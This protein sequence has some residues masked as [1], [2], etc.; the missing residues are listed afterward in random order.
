M[1][2]CGFRGRGAPAR[3]LPQTIRCEPVN[4]ARNSVEAQIEALARS[5]EPGIRRAVLAALQQQQSKVVLRALVE[6]IKT[7]STANVLSVL[8]KAVTPASL[9]SVQQALFSGATGAGVAVA[10]DIARITRTDFAFG[11]LNPRLIEWLQ[12]Y[13]FGLIREIND[14]TREGVR[15]IVSDGIRTGKGPVDTARQIKQIVGLTERQA[16]AVAN[17]RRELETFHLKR[18]A[19]S[20][21]LGREI[22]R[23][24]G[25]QVFKPGD[26][27]TAKDGIDQR[28]L[29]DFRFDGKLASAVETGKPLDPKQI[30]KMV[31]AYAAKYRRYRSETIAITEASRVTTMGVQDA[32]RQA[33]EANVADEALVRRQ[34]VVSADERLCPECAPV[35]SMN[36]RRGV[37]FNEPFKTPKGPVFLPGLHPRCRCKVFIRLLEKSQLENENG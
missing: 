21:G 24:N 35:P 10:R 31:D 20:Y 3:Y 7:G 34:W 2:C 36:P 12:T 19:G 37:K 22:D 28:R 4:K 8:E 30:D 16:K 1:I 15:A 18:S 14:K 25:R 11:V 29:R 26:D 27:G 6:A 5:L 23:V 13:S 33:I 32:W 9:A 17:Y